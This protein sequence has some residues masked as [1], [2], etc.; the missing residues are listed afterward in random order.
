MLRDALYLAAL[1]HDI[2]KFVE[3]SKS[4]PVDEKFKHIRVGHPKYSAQLLD[5]MRK[6]SQ[7]FQRYNDDLID[8]VLYHHEPRTDWGIIIQLADWLSSSEREKGDTQENYYTVPLRPIFSRILDFQSNEFG[9]GLSPLSISSGF[10]EKKPTITINLYKKIVDRFLSELSKVDN[11]TQLYFLLEK[12]LWCVPAQT[13]DYIPDISLFDHAKTTAAIALC[14]YDEY[15]AGS[16]TSENLKKMKNN[17]DDHFILI[18]GDISGIQD[19][20]FKIPSKGAAKTL[21]GHS[22]YISL[23]TDVLTRYLVRELNLKEANVLYNGGGNFYIL[24]PKVCKEKF[25]DLRRKIAQQL[26]RFHGGAIYVALDYV[27]LS[28]KDF[29][30]FNLQWEKVKQ[31]VNLLKNKKWAEIGLKDNYKT[32][33][34]PIGYGSEENGHCYLCGIEGEERKIDYNV[35]TEKYCC[36]FCSSFIDLTDNLKDADCL[37]I[38]EVKG[39]KEQIIHN[40]QDVFNVFGLDYR[41]TTRQKVNQE[42]KKNAFILN[43]TEFIKD[44]FRGFRFGAYQLPYKYNVDERKNQQLTFE[45]ISE[46][47]TGDPKLALLKLDVDNLG[48]LFFHGLGKKA[49]ISRVAS[50]SRMMALYFEGYI[51]HLIIEKNWQ[52]YLYVVFSGGDDTFIVGAWDKVLDFTQEFYDQFHKFTCHHPLITFSVGICVF[53]YNYPIMM[54]SR[55]TEEALETAKSYLVPG[56]TSPSKDKVFLFGEV[57]NWTEF[58]C[59]RNFKDLLMEIM[60]NN[61]DEGE[62]GRAFLYRIWKSTLGFKKILQDSLRGRVDNVRF[63]RLAY[64]LRNVARQDAKKLIAEYREI[65]INNILGKSTD[66][67]ISNIMVVPAAVK[68]AQMETR[69]VRGRE[70]DR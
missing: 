62:F 29:T 44:G 5:E 39:H 4:Y 52:D 31:R 27:L 25:L 33:F 61:Q 14:L 3:R 15:K 46:K 30:E 12:Y 57:F 28:P 17:S 43:D 47:S 7:Y 24:A 64:Y 9:Y 69:K 40:Y 63:W 19:F 38:Q 68:W 23:L 54:S 8:L 1:M 50:L 45:E 59:I 66:E 58:A 11:E 22:V 56:E 32:I 35:E 53:N 21:K 20:I 26:L 37:V 36:T 67:K 16:L 13:T 51:N 34:G 42:E 60:T 18:N 65:V 49:T 48:N 10:P 70:D 2:G 55:M 41:F 6:N